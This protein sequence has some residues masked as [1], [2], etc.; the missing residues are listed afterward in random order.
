MK[1]IV[2]KYGYSIGIISQLLLIL[3]LISLLPDTNEIFRYAARY[4]GRFS[5]SMYIISLL[6]FINYFSKN[7]SIELTKKVLSIFALIHL[8]HFCTNSQRCTPYSMR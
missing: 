2:L 1:N 5:L 7:H 3:A 8:I 4:S 6:S